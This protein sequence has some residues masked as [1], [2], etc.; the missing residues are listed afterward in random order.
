M[1]SGP[2]FATI[3]FVVR[4]RQSAD[5]DTTWDQCDIL[6]WAAAELATG[7]LCVC[8]PEV[9][10][11]LRKRNR[12]GSRPQPQPSASHLQ[13]RWN[14]RVIKKPA[15]SYFSKSLMNSVL[16]TRA[17][18]DYIELQDRRNRHNAQ[19]EITRPSMVQE[20][21]DGVILLRTEVKVEHSVQVV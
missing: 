5:K 11:L 17:D 2:V 7:N 20:P 3:G 1:I 21:E 6:L 15:D 14:E 4:L 9:A 19:V 16:G 12:M 10:F 8:F 13:R 18:N